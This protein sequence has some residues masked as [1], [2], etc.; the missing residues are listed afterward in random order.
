MYESLKMLLTKISSYGLCVKLE[1]TISKFLFMHECMVLFVH[2]RIISI[3][4]IPR[5]D[6][7]LES[8]YAVLV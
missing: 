4:G 6:A 5:C 3:T 7:K 1:L 8:K 2:T